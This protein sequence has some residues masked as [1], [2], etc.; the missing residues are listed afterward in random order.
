MAK[1]KI[2][3]TV[4]L[5]ALLLWKVHP[6][7]IYTA[8]KE[9]NFNGL[10][11]AVVLGLVMVL[12]RWWKWHVLVK[13]GLK[14]G[15]P[16]QSLVSLLGGMAFALVT[17][18][19][20]GEL[21]RALFFPK[22]T[23][24]QVGML[25]F[26]DRVIDLFV[27]LLYASLGATSRVSPV[28]RIVLGATMAVLAFVVL[29]FDWVVRLLRRW[30][31]GGWLG[32]RLAGLDQVERNLRH[33]TILKNFILSCSLTFFDLI[34]FFVLL[35]CFVPTVSF[36]VVLLVFPLV[37]LVNVAP[38]TISGLGLREGTA[39]ALLAIFKI[40]SAAAFNATFLSYIL[41]SVAPAVVGAIYA[42]NMKVSFSAQKPAP[43]S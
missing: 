22:G 14:A 8:L 9:A 26:L 21:S 32:S 18:A 29:R 10:V 43:Q 31:Q 6:R 13:D 2:V 4:L 28:F 5:L 35:R 33:V 37:L 25:T 17:P 3:V 30:F 38:I 27:V 7:H 39:I 40:S 20:V 11:L 23:K 1:I 12:L 15:G 36:S 24:T 19:R 34:T 41:N 16:K 42:R